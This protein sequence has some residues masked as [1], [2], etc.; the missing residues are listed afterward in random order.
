MVQAVV[1]LGVRLRGII[2]LI[3]A[4]QDLGRLL[5]VVA[6][7]ATDEDGADV[8]ARRQ[9]LSHQIRHLVLIEPCQ[10]LQDVE[11]RG[12]PEVVDLGRFAMLDGEPAIAGKALQHFAQGSAS[13]ANQLGQ[14]AL[15]RQNGSW[16]KAIVPDG[17]DDVFLGKP[18]RALRF[19][20]HVVTLL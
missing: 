14:F 2:N 7:G 12:L 16:R 17:L 13:H 8:G 1:E 18:G 11:T 3:G 6:N 19:Y 15:R 9:Q 10:G 5:R 4:A 20:D